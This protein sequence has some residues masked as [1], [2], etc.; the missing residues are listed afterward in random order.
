MA[1]VTPGSDPGSQP[2]TAGL[3]SM[4]GLYPDSETGTKAL[5]EMSLNG[6]IFT[7]DYERH[8]VRPLFTVANIPYELWTTDSPVS[9]PN[10]LRGLKL[11]TTGGAVGEY[12]QSVGASPTQIDIPETFGAL[13]SGV[14]DGVIQD[15]TNL[16]AFG[17]SPV[18]KYA[19]KGLT[20][21]GASFGYVIDQSVYDNLTEEQR[22]VFDE[23]GKDITEKYS[24]HQ[25]DADAR[26]KASE[27]FANIT[28]SDVPERELEAWQRTFDDFT[29]NYLASR[30]EKFMAA[31]EE[32]TQ[33]INDAE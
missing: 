20:L 9:H 27:S 26:L 28:F 22:N 31:Y 15:S 32:F 1:F 12:L 8:G 24:T 2:I 33:K 13:D 30:D 29:T 23:A 5:T 11:R 3:I 19:N 25:Q 10:D 4:P 17:L 21:G 7:E 6:P 14:I 18:V 16:E